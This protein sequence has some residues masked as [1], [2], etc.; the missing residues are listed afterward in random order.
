M[1]GS[2]CGSYVRQ[3]QQFG[4]VVG[5]VINAERCPSG[6]CSGRVAKRLLLEFAQV[7]HVQIPAGLE[8]VF[9]GLDG[10]RPDQSQAAWGL[11]R[12]LVRCDASALRAARTADR[13]SRKG[14]TRDPFEPAWDRTPG[15][16]V[17]VR[18]RHAVKKA[19]SRPVTC[20]YHARVPMDVPVRNGDRPSRRRVSVVMGS[21]AGNAKNRRECGG[22]AVFGVV[23]RS[24]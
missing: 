22:P 6:D 14:V 15:F 3:V 5:P 7:V 10:L 2:A 18:A 17:A 23:S 8:P 21:I 11:G 13:Q 12:I 9:V 24:V 4:D 20:G 16:A 19:S 1:P